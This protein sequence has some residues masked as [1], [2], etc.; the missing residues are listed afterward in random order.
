MHE[1]EI[2]LRKMRKTKTE[3]KIIQK[4]RKERGKKVQKK[5]CR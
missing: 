3:T 5:R 2:K 4:H 1:S